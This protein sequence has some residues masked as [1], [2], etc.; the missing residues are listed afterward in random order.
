MLVRYEDLHS[1]TTVQAE[2]IGS[3]L[4]LSHD[5]VSSL[6]SQLRGQMRLP[7]KSG[8]SAKADI[9]KLPTE[10]SS[11]LVDYMK[12]LLRPPSA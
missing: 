12:R 1:D 2:R 5:E 10:W 4:S 11:K 6:A 9:D 3:F 7:T 8:D